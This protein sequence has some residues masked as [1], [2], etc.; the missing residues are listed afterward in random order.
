MDSMSVQFS[1]KDLMAVEV[2]GGM[3]GDC[4]VYH[5]GAFVYGGL[6][7]VELV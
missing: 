4:G 1:L 7:I 2:I 5:V 3:V 6:I